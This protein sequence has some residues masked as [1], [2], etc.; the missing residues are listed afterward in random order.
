MHSDESLESKQL[1]AFVALIVRNEMFKSLEPLRKKDRKKF[2]IPSALRE[3]DR[4][5]ITR[6]SDGIFNMRYALTAA[7]KDIFKCIGINEEDVRKKAGEI[8]KRYR[9]TT[10]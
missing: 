8:S 4:V 6:D 3:L 2:T 10:I 1:T 5:I 7:Q 9:K